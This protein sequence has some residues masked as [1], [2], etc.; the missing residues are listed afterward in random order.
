MGKSIWTV[1]PETERL[2]LT[3]RYR[4]EAGEQQDVPFWLDVKKFLTVGE[5]RRLET[6]GFGSVE[7]RQRRSDEAALMTIDWQ[8]MSFAQAE[9]YIVDWS[10]KDEREVKLPITRETIESLAK[11]VFTLIDEALKAH[12]EAME[13]KSSG[14]TKG[15]GQSRRRTSA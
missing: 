6:A 14:K 8:R 10:L 9:I 1:E 15:G 2:E 4:N 7:A 12:V 5:Q 3:Y 13:E 11:P